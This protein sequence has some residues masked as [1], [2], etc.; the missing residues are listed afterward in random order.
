MNAQLAPQPPLNDRA[1]REV[2]TNPTRFRDWLEMDPSAGPLISRLL[3]S[4]IDVGDEAEWTT[5]VLAE[6]LDAMRM[7]YRVRI[8]QTRIMAAQSAKAMGGSR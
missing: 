8:H 5:D 4:G 3:A 7:H 1:E 6:V 2:L